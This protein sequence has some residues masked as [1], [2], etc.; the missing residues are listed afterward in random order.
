MKKKMK[1]S[2]HEIPKQ[3]I[4]VPKFRRFYPSLNFV[5]RQMRGH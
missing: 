1:D 4:F 5:I 2:S 3:G